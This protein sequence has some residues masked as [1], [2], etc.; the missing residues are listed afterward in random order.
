MS[1]RHQGHDPEQQKVLRELQDPGLQA[2]LRME[3]PPAP[4][5]AAAR[6][7]GAKSRAD[8]LEA[9]VARQQRIASFRAATCD[10]WLQAKLAGMLWGWLYRLCMR[11]PLLLWCMGI[12]TFVDH[13]H[14][15]VEGRTLPTTVVRIQWLWWVLKIKH[16][17]WEAK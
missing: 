3:R 5:R 15:P 10:Q 2:I 7:A 13:G 14:A 11:R 16:F 4:N 17:A 12:G 6:A 9:E 8:Q 1:R